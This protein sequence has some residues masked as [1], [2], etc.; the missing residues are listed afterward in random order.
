MLL[1][2]QNKMSAT[3]GHIC[4]T[5]NSINVHRSVDCD[6]AGPRCV[7][8]CAPCKENYDNKINHLCKSCG[9]MNVHQSAKCDGLGPRCIFNC[10][11]CVEKL[12][13]A[14]ADVLVMWSNASTI[15]EKI[16]VKKYDEAVK[17]WYLAQMKIKNELDRKSKH[18][19]EQKYDVSDVNGGLNKL[20]KAKDFIEHKNEI[21]SKNESRSLTIDSNTEIVTFGDDGI[22]KAKSI[23]TG[24]QI[25]GIIL[26]NQTHNEFIYQ[27]RWDGRIGLPGGQVEAQETE[28]AAAVREMREESGLDILNGGTY[29]FKCL[30]YIKNRQLSTGNYV[31][32]FVIETNITKWTND[33]THKNEVAKCEFGKDACFGHAWF[34][35]ASTYNDAK[36]NGI[37]YQLKCLSKFIKLL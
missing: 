10:D 7:L 31:I 34:A 18:Q 11:S 21:K 29:T 15:E 24:S 2:E 13:Q 28:F 14:M 3:T 4:R 5:C 1:T 9:A 22:N 30:G 16:T 12:N 37:K 36:F 17:R 6:Y 33:G 25:A 8:G 27:T 20:T 23:S 35:R 32:N 26:V 19:L